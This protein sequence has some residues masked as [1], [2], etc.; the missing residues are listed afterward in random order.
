MLKR[1]GIMTVMAALFWGSGAQANDLYIEQVGDG[2]TVT[3]TQDGSSNRIGTSN[4]PSI[5]K[6]DANLVTIDQ[7]G[8]SN[9]LD[10]VIN[11]T[12]VT[13]IVTTNGSNNIQTIN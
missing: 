11:G 13:A 6:G 9:E 3:I 5:F 2:A 7:I 4:T 12:A 1:L 8:S 10:I